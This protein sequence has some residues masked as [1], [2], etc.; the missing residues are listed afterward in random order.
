M[1]MIAIAPSER[2]ES[3]SSAVKRWINRETGPSSAAV[4][5]SIGSGIASS[6]PSEAA[7][8]EAEPKAGSG[9]EAALAAPNANPQY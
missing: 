6:S 1:T 3:V 4:S 8:S 9:S 7:P 5:A 2:P